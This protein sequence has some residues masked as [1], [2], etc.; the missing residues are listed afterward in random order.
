LLAVSLSG[1]NSSLES[2]RFP[3][4]TGLSQVFIALNTSGMSG[5]DVITASIQQTID[6][7]H[8]TPPAED[9]GKVLYPGERMLQTRQANLEL[10]IPVDQVYWE[11]VLKL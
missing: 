4:E 11:Q 9:G 5:Q 2:G 6:D 10:G 1:G 7:L 8:V 3:V